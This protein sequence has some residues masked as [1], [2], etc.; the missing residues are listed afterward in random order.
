MRLELCL[1]ALNGANP[2]P[3]SHVQLAR[4][5]ELSGYHAVWVPELLSTDPYGLL[6]WIGAHTETIRLGS[7]VAQIAAR[8]AVTTASCAATLD[9]LSGGR[10]LLGLGVSSPRIVEGWHGLQYHR[11]LLHLR[12]Y[13]EVVRAALSG[14]P[15]S[16]E[17]QTITLPAR[18]ETGSVTPMALPLGRP[19]P[20][21]LAG[22]GPQAVRLAG[23]LADGLIH[24]PPEYMKS[25]RSWLEE[26][27]ECSGRSLDGFAVRVMMTVVV[28]DDLG[29]ARDLVRPTLAL[30]VGGM[31]TKDTN[32]YNRL[33]VRL[34]FAH[35]AFEVQEA[36][37]SGDIGQ[38][39]DSIPDAMV[40]AMSVCGPP[41]LVAAK[42]DQYRDAGVDAVIVGVSGSTH[43]ERT[44]QIERIAA[45]Y[46]AG[47]TGYC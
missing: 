43:P 2:S 15:I 21:H 23:E 29:L 1:P 5:A 42:L 14:E 33:A 13:V 18:S 41:E 22:L 25:A 36:F 46:P 19:L 11:P 7:A 30:F 27:A 16:Y 44:E 40:D 6:A 45:L 26:G 17:G 34:G 32:F 8:T 12:E 9:A 28:D 38:A 39:I 24:C 10:L 20:L 35:Q 37:I 31:G 47:L 3:A 4:T